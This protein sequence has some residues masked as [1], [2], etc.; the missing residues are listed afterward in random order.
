MDFNLPCWTWVRETASFSGQRREHRYWWTEEAPAYPK[1]QILRQG[2]HQALAVVQHIDFLPLLLCET[3][4]VPHAPH[5]HHGAQR[6][7]DDTEPVSYT[8]LTAMTGSRDFIDMGNGLRMSLARNK[9][10]ANRLDIIY[11]EG[12]DLYNCLLYTSRCV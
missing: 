3:V 7:E 1:G 12:A 6:E 9:T 8:H 5:R 10:S 4:G 2:E 11:D